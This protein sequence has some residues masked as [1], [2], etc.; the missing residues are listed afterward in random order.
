MRDLFPVQPV[1]IT[2]LALVVAG[3]LVFF[4][5]L[6]RRSFGRAD[7]EEGARK[8]GLSRIGILLQM[9]AFAG[10]GF[11]GVKPALAP[12]SPAALAGAVAVALLM[13]GAILLFAAAT[14][15]M[16][17][18]WSVTARTRADHELVTQGV[19]ARLRHPI[20]TGM[21]LFLAA[22]AIAFGHEANLLIGLPLFI[23]GTWIRIS[24]EERLLHE[25]FGAS[26]DAYARQVRR[27]VPGLF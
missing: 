7:G 10:T 22:E 11:G 24:E 25:R 19:F 17:A 6:L 20:Y 2:G 16:G 15:A 27:F 9:I 3:G 4:A 1:G 23:A 8:S 13:G 21:A 18:N 5:L 12:F 26:Y 14:R